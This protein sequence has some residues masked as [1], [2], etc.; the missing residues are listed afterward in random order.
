MLQFGRLARESK[1]LYDSVKEL[2]DELTQLNLYY[3]SINSS[4]ITDL[5]NTYGIDF[6]TDWTNESAYSLNSILHSWWVGKN[7]WN[8][9]QETFQ[10]NPEHTLNLAV[11][12]A[13]FNGLYSKAKSL[14]VT[15]SDLTTLD[16][17]IDGINYDDLPTQNSIIGKILNDIDFF[18]TDKELENEK[19]II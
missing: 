10:T 17:T 2:V 3:P 1:E 19:Y 11:F 5:Q 14:V 15:D 4:H 13:P 12:D 9:A 6:T 8:Q 16:E 7:I 18:H